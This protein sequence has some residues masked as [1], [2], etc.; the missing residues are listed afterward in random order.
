[1]KMYNFDNRVSKKRIDL[2]YAQLLKEKK[3]IK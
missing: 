2:L 1:M 3:Q